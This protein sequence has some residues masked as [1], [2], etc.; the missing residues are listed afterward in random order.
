MTKNWPVNVHRAQ[1]MRVH[2]AATMGSYAVSGRFKPGVAGVAIWDAGFRGADERR[3]RQMALLKFRFHVDMRTRGFL[4]ARRL[5]GC[6]T[7][8]KKG[9][10]LVTGTQGV[11]ADATRGARKAYSASQDAIE[12]RFRIGLRCGPSVRN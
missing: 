12:P 6:D 7:G 11:A 3:Y 10:E 1:N 5:C 4:G 9:E 2:K 8:A